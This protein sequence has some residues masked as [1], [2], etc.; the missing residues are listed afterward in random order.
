M[1]SH[2]LVLIL[3]GQNHTR[4]TRSRTPLHVLDIL[5]K[6]SEKRRRE[7]VRRVE[8]VKQENFTADVLGYG[9]RIFY[10]ACDHP[11]LLA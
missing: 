11:T 6:L 9:N 3:H 4:Y 10:W 1:Y 2:E 5:D 8:S 7:Y